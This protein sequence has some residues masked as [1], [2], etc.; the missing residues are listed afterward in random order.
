MTYHLPAMLTV[1]KILEYIKVHKGDYP[2]GDA[3]KGK[4]I[5]V[6][7]RSEVVGRPLAA[8]LSND[9][10]KVYSVDIGDI[11]ELD[12]PEVL[13]VG[14]FKV[15]LTLI[16]G[17]QSVGTL[18]NAASLQSKLSE[19]TLEE[20]LAIS[21]VVISGVPTASYK[22]STKSLKP[23]IVAINFSHFNNYQDDITDVASI[24]VPSIG[25]VTVTMLQR[26][27]LKIYNYSNGYSQPPANGVNGHHKK[28]TNC[29]G[30]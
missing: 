5:T 28:K 9:G 1:S 24:F 18:V 21:D 4:T 30:N 11:L 15:R 23:G 14:S 6:I 8:M 10:A 17:N 2:N 20:A 3:L 19:K 12:P 25:K 27:L 29:T 26:N 13:G 16:T 7:N 22:I